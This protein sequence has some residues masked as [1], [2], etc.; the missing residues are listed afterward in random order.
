MAEETKAP[1]EVLRKAEVAAE[2]GTIEQF[3]YKQ[4]LK[5]SLTLKDIVLYG[6]LFMVIIA[7]Q[8]IYGLVQQ[9]SHGMAPLVYII[10]FLAIS[11]TAMSYM[12]MSNK[13]PIAGSVYAYV[14]RG[15]NPHI[16]FLAGWL[17]L[18]DYVFVPALL[19]IMVANW[20]TLLI[21]GSPWYLWVIV[22]VVFNTFVNIRGLGMTKGV[23]WVMFAI[24]ILLLIA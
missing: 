13:F 11:F 9:Q 14:Q 15:I 4:E 10:G 3:G 2:E 18:L 1:V 17:I 12:R 21:P 7:P 16:G 23:D 5:R 19:Y 6:V 8:S 20:G 24:E 22:F